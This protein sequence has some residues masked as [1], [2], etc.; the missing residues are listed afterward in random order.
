MPTTRTSGAIFLLSLQ[1]NSELICRINTGTT[2]EPSD[3]N[4]DHISSR[5]H[6][7]VTAVTIALNNQVMLRKL[8]AR[9]IHRNNLRLM[10][11]KA[12]DLNDEDAVRVAVAQ[13]VQDRDSEPRGCLWKL[14][15]CTV[16]PILR[17]FNILL[18]A[19]T[20]VDRVFKLTAEIQELQTEKYD[21]SKVFVTFETEE[22]Q[23]AALTALSIGRLDIMMNNKASVSPS[24]VFQGT[25]LK[26]GEPSEPSAVR[27]LDLSAST[28]RKVCI[29]GLN[30]G[31]TLLVVSFAGFLATEARYNIGYLAWWKAVL[32]TF[33]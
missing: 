23:R 19:E 21:V 18:P 17:I 29:R 7:R 12:T 20:L 24:A 1:R 5:F 27:W 4:A 6:H 3:R 14:F 28:M 11:P 15:D 13:F 25:L 32:T 9:R 10:L 22:G 30:L 8:I 16:L 26:V 2:S 33:T 31:I